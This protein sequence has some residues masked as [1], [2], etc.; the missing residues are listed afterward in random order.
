MEAIGGS[1]TDTP[2]SWLHLTGATAD[3]QHVTA[4]ISTQSYRNSGLAAQRR[5]FADRLAERQSLTIPAADP[6]YED[7]GPAFPAWTASRRDA[8]LQQPKPE[9]RPSTL[10]LERAADRDADWEAAD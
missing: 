8:I 5:A 10:V 7:L 3:L 4:A 2:I 9:I 1:G 6:D